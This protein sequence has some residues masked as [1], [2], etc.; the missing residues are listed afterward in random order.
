MG[1]IQPVAQKLTFS[2][3]DA[4]KKGPRTVIAPKSKPLS[5]QSEDDKSN[6]TTP[7]TPAAP[8]TPTAPVAQIDLNDN[9]TTAVNHQEPETPAAS[10]ES[11]PSHDTEILDGEKVKPAEQKSHD[12]PKLAL[13]QPLVSYAEAVKGLSS[14]P[15]VKSAQDKN[16]SKSIGGPLTHR[17]N[18]NAMNWLTTQSPVNGE[19]VKAQSPKLQQ[20]PIPN[21]IVKRAAMRKA[22]QAAKV[23]SQRAAAQKE[24][25][26]KTAQKLHSQ[27]LNGQR[28]YQQ[29]IAQ[30]ELVRRSELHPAAAPFKPMAAL[31][32]TCFQSDTYVL[33][34]ADN[35]CSQRLLT[36]TVATTTHLTHVLMAQKCMHCKE[37]GL[38]PAATIIHR[39]NDD[40]WASASFSP[41]KVQTDQSFHD[42]IAINSQKYV[43]G[44]PDQ[45]PAQSR[46]YDRP[47]I[48]QSATN[49]AKNG[50]IDGNIDADKFYEPLREGLLLMYK[51]EGA[52]MLPLRA[53]VANVIDACLMYLALSDQFQLELQTPVWSSILLPK[54]I[55][56]NQRFAE[57]GLLPPLLKDP[58]SQAEWEEHQG[59]ATL[60]LWYEAYGPSGYERIKDLHEF[61]TARTTQTKKYLESR[62]YTDSL[63]G[64]DIYNVN[65]ALSHI[66]E[67]ADGVVIDATQTYYEANEAEMEREHYHYKVWVGLPPEVEPSESDYVVSRLVVQAGQENPLPEGLS[68]NSESPSKRSD[69]PGH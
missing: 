27:V 18:A 12:E 5:D 65:L 60:L 24:V 25:T 28:A 45:K 7:P 53:A 62:E 41:E 47:L 19:S 54:L 67:V 31:Q 57:M 4:L 63:S 42:R 46:I 33:T 13:R 9:T 16:S 64:W 6:L 17:K 58:I 23:A 29:E 69:A 1:S 11:A 10:E 32:Q 36:S 34:A 8:Q 26:R 3:A 55:Q 22:V 15:K 59:E 30:A 21:L 35:M 61:H 56:D 40:G 49:Y 39:P 51:E 43:D 2:Y 14:T 38:Y 48:E 50:N 37:I 20:I 68:A 44:S 66:D 52:D